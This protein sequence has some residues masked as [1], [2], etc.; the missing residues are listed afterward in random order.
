MGA[1]KHMLAQRPRQS[2]GWHVLSGGRPHPRNICLFLPQR[3]WAYKAKRPLS[4]AKKQKLFLSESKTKP[5]LPSTSCHSPGLSLRDTISTHTL[6][7]QGNQYENQFIHWYILSRYMWQC[8]ISFTVEPSGKPRSR[9]G[10][11][12][13]GGREGEKPIFC[14]GCK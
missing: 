14:A 1:S 13:A 2:P 8:H 11:R 7:V 9:A 12:A 10:K 4:Q 5:A 6:L 3:G